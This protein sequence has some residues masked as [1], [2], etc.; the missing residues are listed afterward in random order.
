MKLNEITDNE[1]ALKRR[2]RVGRGIGSGTGKTGG[3]GGEGPE[4]PFR[5]CHQRF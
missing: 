2:K 5:R 3:R 4:G 1:G